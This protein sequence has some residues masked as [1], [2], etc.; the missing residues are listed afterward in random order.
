M[1]L[2]NS[3]NEDGECHRKCRRNVIEIVIEILRKIK[4]LKSEYSKIKLSKE[5]RLKSFLKNEYFKVS[6]NEVSRD[7]RLSETL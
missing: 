6:L 4:W 5:R 2:S 7:L 1:G 3:Y